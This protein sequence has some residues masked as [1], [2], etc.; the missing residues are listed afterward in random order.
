MPKVSAARP[1][2][3]RSAEGGCGFIDEAT[4]AWAWDLFDKVCSENAEEGGLYLA[5]T[6]QAGSTA[7]SLYFSHKL[8]PNCAA[9]HVYHEFIQFIVVYF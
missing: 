2:V 1:R 7:I 6:T 9:L 4:L 5:G 8:Q 3:P